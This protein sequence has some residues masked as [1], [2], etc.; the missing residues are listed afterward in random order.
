MGTIQFIEPLLNIPWLLAMVG[1]I[2]MYIRI[3]KVLNKR[4]EANRR[5]EK[6][7]KALQILNQLAKML[8]V[9]GVVFFLRHI[10][11]RE[12]SLTAWICFIAQISNH[13]CNTIVGI[14]LW[15]CLIPRPIN[16]VANPSI[17]GVMNSQYRAVF[18]QAFHCKSQPTQRVPTPMIR[19]TTA[20]NTITNQINETRL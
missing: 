13:L 1:N 14:S 15:I 8:I 16:T 11:F 9:N 20:I 2:Y 18:I 5:L 4:R 17:H 12:V 7:Q 6:D 19:N 10:P 3:I